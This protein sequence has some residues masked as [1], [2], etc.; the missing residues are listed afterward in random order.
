MNNTI[1]I[2]L[3]AP[4]L[5]NFSNHNYFHLTAQQC[6]L[7]MF[8]VIFKLMLI[9]VPK[10]ID[11]SG[12][13]GCDK[14]FNNNSIPTYISSLINQQNAKDPSRNHDVAMFRLERTADGRIFQETISEI[15]KHNSN[16]PVYSHT[17]LEPILSYR[18]HASSFY[19]ITTDLETEEY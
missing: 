8:L 2:F 18:V 12:W 10:M 15:L 5:N 14:D 9:T 13:Q 7:E 19:V 1:L 3:I 6:I 11:S 4:A 16:N 17:S